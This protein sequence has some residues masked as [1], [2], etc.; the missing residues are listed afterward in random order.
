[1]K[2]NLKNSG[3]TLIETLVAIG[4]FAFSI[5][6]LISVTANGVFNTNFVKNK[7]TAGY[8]AI[9][10]AE[11]VRN[12]RDTAAIQNNGW[13][14]IM[15]TSPF[16]GNCERSVGGTEACTIDA[17]TTSAPAACPSEG[18]LA[19]TLDTDSGKFSYSP[20]DPFTLLQSIFTR[21]IYIETIN[22]KESRVTS[23]VEWRQGANLH[24]VTY[25]YDLLNWNSN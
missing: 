16:L 19:M 14:A 21:T 15:T 2:K 8:L 11:L 12:I 22:N 24:N 23:K 7:F 20:Q 13:T 9:E 3:F 17:W 5:T 1:M 4:I 6:G 18:C 10:G 25:T